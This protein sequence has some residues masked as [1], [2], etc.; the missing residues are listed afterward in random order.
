MVIREHHRVLLEELAL[1][2]L[3]EIRFDGQA[4]LA[5]RRLPEL[6]VVRSGD[7]EFGRFKMATATF[8]PPAP[9]TASTLEKKPESKPDSKPTDKAADNPESKPESKPEAR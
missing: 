2:R 4:E 8:G 5:G 3:F 1:F 6:F 9:V 7:R